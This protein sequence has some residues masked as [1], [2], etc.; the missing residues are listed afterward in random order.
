MRGEELAARPLNPSLSVAAADGMR[1]DFVDR[2]TYRRKAEPDVLA[3]LLARH[4]R[5]Y[6]LPEGGS[7]AAAAAGCADL[8]R[9]LRGAADVVAV[10]CGTGGTLAGLAAGLADGPGRPE[11]AEAIGFPVL[12]G[13]AFLAADVLRLQQEA[14]GGAAAAGGSTTASTTAASPGP[15]RRS[16]SSPRTSAY[17]TAWTRRRSTWRRCCTAW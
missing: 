9:E 12:R 8:G 11:C 5:A 2:A 13:G 14:F 16:T 6:V 3:A 10:A 15:A 1:L 17:G 7:N 4:G